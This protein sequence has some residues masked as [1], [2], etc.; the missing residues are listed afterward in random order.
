MHRNRSYVPVVW[1]GMVLFD[2][3]VEHTNRLIMAHHNSM[4]LLNLKLEKGGDTCV[5]V[6]EKE[7]NSFY[8]ARPSGRLW[9]RGFPNN[10]PGVHCLIFQLEMKILINNLVCVINAKMFHGGS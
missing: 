5:A 9:F 3:S 2:P 1:Y 6:K 10:T 7:A 4:S 8:L